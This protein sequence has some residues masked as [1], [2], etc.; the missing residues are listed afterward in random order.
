MRLDFSVPQK[1]DDLSPWQLGK[2]GEI[3][4]SKKELEIQSYKWLVVIILFLPYPSIRNIGKLLL[5]LFTIPLKQLEQYADFVF[6]ENL[7]MTTFPTVSKIRDKSGKK[8]FLI[9]PAPRM[10]NSNIMELSY[11]DTFYYQW[12]KTG[13]DIHL[14]R[15]CAVLYRP[16]GVPD[17]QSTDKRLPFNALTL[18]E[19]AY[20]TD[21]IPVGYMYMI[22]LAYEGT[23]QVLQRRYTRIFPQR[24][25]T[26]EPKHGNAKYSPFSK[27]VTAMAL[28][29][30]NPF[31]TLEGAERS[32]AHK[33]L[34]VYN[35]QLIRMDKRQQ[36]LDKLKRHG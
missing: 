22:G 26:K 36:E 7:V 31:G 19:N 28:D 24:K 33:F 14:K 5:L 11:A 4:A 15:L 3:F 23:R 1:W 34:E 17:F 6:D 8:V 13:D 30:V 35:E 20:L 16:E 9:G 12:R 25:Q 29:E 10:S 32:N 2:L 21:Q 27:I 18:T